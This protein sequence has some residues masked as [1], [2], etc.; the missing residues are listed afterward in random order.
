MM[1]YLVDLQMAQEQRREIGIPS[2]GTSIDLLRAVYRDP[3]IPLSTRIRCAVAALP[4]ELPKLAVT[5]MVTE[6]DFATLLDQRIKRM[7]QMERKPQTIDV[8]PPLP[9]L[10]DR[11]YRRI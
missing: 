4:F 6:Q 8:K 1:N 9:R 5:A 7:E 2:D 11:R 3:S 10:A